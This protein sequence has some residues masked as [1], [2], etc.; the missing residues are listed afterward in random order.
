MAIWSFI[1]FL[2]GV[3]AL[4][5]HLFNFFEWF[6]PFWAIVLMAISLGMLARISQKEKEGEKE[7]LV[8]RIQDLEVQLKREKEIEKTVEEKLTEVSQK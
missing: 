2:I 8:E 3:F 5:F 1:I 7:K 4:I 6:T